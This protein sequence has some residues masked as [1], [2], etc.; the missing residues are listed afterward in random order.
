MWALQD[1]RNRFSAVEDETLAG[2]PQELSRRGKPAVVVLSATEMPAC[3]R[4]PR[5]G[6][7]ATTPATSSVSAKI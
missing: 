3:A 1:A 2:P 4:P 6:A 5:P 7:D